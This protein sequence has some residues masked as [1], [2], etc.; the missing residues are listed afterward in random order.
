VGCFDYD[1]R[2]GVQELGRRLRARLANEPRPVHLVGHSMGGLVARAALAGEAAHIIG[3]IITLGTPHAGSYAPLQALRGV[4]GTV[5]RLAQLDPAH[6]AEALAERVFGGFPSLYDMLPRHAAPDWL[7]ADSW[8]DSAPLPR[9]DELDRAAALCLPDAP[10]RLYCIAGTG[11]PTVTAARAESRRL[12]YRLD[13]H[14]DGTVPVASAVLAGHGHRY[15]T[16]PH[17][18]LPRDADVAA[19]VADLLESGGTTRLSMSEPATVPPMPPIDVDESEL[20]ALFNEKLDWQA[21]SAEERRAWL[22]SLN[23]PVLPLAT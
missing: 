17:S 14:G 12:I 21:M 2:H 19:A 16:V 5:R 11:Q 6:S 1:W 18:E 23:S 7:R 3:R 20:R 15:T 9:A 8:P 13:A 10:D 22:D 4:Y